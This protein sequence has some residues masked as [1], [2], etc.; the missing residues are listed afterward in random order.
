MKEII[1]E[2]L[3]NKNGLLLIDA[4]TGIGKSYSIIEVMLDLLEEMNEQS[5]PIFFITNLTKNLPIKEFEKKARERGLAEAYKKYVLYLGAMEKSVY[6]HLLELESEIPIYIK[7]TK[8]YQELFNRLDYIKS[9]AENESVDLTSLPEFE[10][11][12]R[13][14][15]INK[16]N[17]LGS[18]Q[19]KLE[20]IETNVNW[21]WVGK[22]YPSV[23]SKKRKIFF[24]SIDKFFLGNPTLVES[25]YQFINKP[26]F[27]QSIIFIDEFD[28]S[29]DSIINQLI[30][31]SSKNA[32]NLIDIF[33]EIYFF[34]DNS[35]FSADIL[36]QNGEKIVS[37]MKVVFKENYQKYCQYRFKTIESLD[38]Q[39][40]R[41][42]LF[43]DGQYL[44][45]KNTKLYYYPDNQ[46]KINWITNE[47]PDNQYI[48]MNEV[49]DRLTGAIHYF[50]NGLR[51]MVGEYFQ[52][53]NSRNRGLTYTNC[54]KSVLN[55]MGLKQT[56]NDYLFRRILEIQTEGISTMRVSTNQEFFVKN[57]YSRGF[58]LYSLIDGDNN[59]FHTD[60]IFYQVPFFPEYYL[61]ELCTKN[62]VFGISAT[63]TVSSVLSN[64]DLEYLKNMLGKKYFTLNQKQFNHLQ[65]SYHQL[66][67]GY[68]QVQIETIAIQQTDLQ[69]Y[70]RAKLDEKI[71]FSFVNDY[72]KMI[73][74]FHIGRFTKML[75]TIVQFLEDKN[76]QSLLIL[77]NKLINEN[78][79]KLNLDLFRK[80]LALF[81]NRFDEKIDLANL[82]VTLDSQN[83]ECQ[84]RA[85]QQRLEQGEKLVI[86]SSYKTVGVGQNLQYNIPNNTKVVQVNDRVSQM[87]D[88]DC[89]YLDNP[90]YLIARNILED[91]SDNDQIIYRGIFQMEYL[92]YT[93]EISY[94][95]AKYF[96]ASYFGK[97]KAYFDNMQ[98]KSMN[99]KAITILQQAVGRIC[100]TSNKNAVIKLFVDYKILLSYDFSD[101]KA[102]LNN[103]E[104]HSLIEC[105]SN[106]NINKKQEF[107]TL[108]NQAVTFTIRFK[109]RLDLILR[110]QNYWNADKINLWE[111]MR[112][113]VLKQ[114]TI[115]T[116]DYQKLDEN[117]QSLY[118]QMPKKQ[119]EY[120]FTQKRDFMDLEI[121]FDLQGRSHV[122]ELDVRL[123]Q[124]GEI[125]ELA[126]F[127]EDNGYALTFEENDYLLSPI[128]FQNI[129]KGA[130]GEVIGQ[131]IM[132][133][134]LNILLEKMPVEQ[135]EKFDYHI[136]NKVFI[137][138]K[139]WKESN[140][141]L[142][143][144][145][146]KKI[147]EKLEKVGG[148]TAIIIN[149]FADRKYQISFS[150]HRKIVE[151]PYLFKQK[152]L[153][154]QI[155]QELQQ[156]IKEG[157]HDDNIN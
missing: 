97:T 15:V 7:K 134:Q 84:K 31:H 47:N 145:Y 22:L 87:R 94:M 46:A 44:Q 140:K 129:Y 112:Q 63:A 2:M 51:K 28:T 124:I 116:V 14:L 89:L 142:A 1:K 80:A 128:V 24:L 33:S 52:S 125:P 27:E 19:T 68:D 120:T 95:Q 90:T 136:Q 72:M 53:A 40:L 45:T 110:Q 11:K 35:Q 111:K 73:D 147:Q 138:F 127:F 92:A 71:A 109:N 49:L 75:D 42:F 67:K 38:G 118:I 55:F 48:S 69:S 155:L 30:A 122:S 126:H 39:S 8:E 117:M 21:Q 77:S 9:K 20:L 59:V 100:R 130:L 61:Y 3:P 93:G 144:D 36:G 102:R 139:Y 131:W 106:N 70:L 132:S 83:F 121:Y 10:W 74:E 114:P 17:E 137:D 76:V 64:Y 135:Y 141:Q 58:K 26:E 65:K 151:I 4:P 54:L 123:N 66:T 99:N 103:P 96:I 25:T 43:N 81:G 78:T 156:I 79:S 23:F 108:Q 91:M 57:L 41:S 119:K 86:F 101:F 107:E 154:T 104:F 115:S 105:S 34:L 88:I 113:Q 148:Q 82:F 62:L 153:N 29:K 18:L 5:R 146:T 6:D 143:K 13:Q 157:L 16:L 149:I 32:V 85:L 150:N 12:F 60:I 56:N 98:L 37:K 133:N 152:Q 50:I